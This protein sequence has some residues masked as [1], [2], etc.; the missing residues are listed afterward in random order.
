[1]NCV[2]AS[3]RLKAED[4]E[5]VTRADALKASILRRLVGSGVA[6][7]VVAHGGLPE[8]WVRRGRAITNNHCLA[9]SNAGS[10][11]SP[12]FVPPGSTILLSESNLRLSYRT[13][14]RWVP[15]PRNPPID[16]TA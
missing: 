16:R 13:T 14:T 8:F 7:F 6:R 10:I 12:S 15:I 5:I 4:P 2:A 9:Y 1:M 11:V 3:R